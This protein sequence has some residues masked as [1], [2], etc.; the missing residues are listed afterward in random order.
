MKNIREDLIDYEMTL[1]GT[2]EENSIKM[3]DSY[4]A[5]KSFSNKPNTIDINIFNQLKEA[6]SRL[7]YGIIGLKEHDSVEL[8]QVQWIINNL[9][10][11]KS[12]IIEEIHRDGGMSI[13]D[14]KD[15][16]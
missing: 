14:F 9:L 10:S 3:V 4:I 15:K 16:K 13:N 2:T 8:K 5:V 6:K 12:K 1:H 7:D 11:N